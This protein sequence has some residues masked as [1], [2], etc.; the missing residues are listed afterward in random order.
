MR[1]AA[2]LVTAAFRYKTQ[3]NGQLAPLPYVN[4]RQKGN[5][6]RWQARAT[7]NQGERKKQFNKERKREINSRLDETRSLRQCTVSGVTWA[8]MDMS[9]WSVSG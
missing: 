6:T 5:R 1:R 8:G 7:Y 4:I 2:K 9:T 3:Q